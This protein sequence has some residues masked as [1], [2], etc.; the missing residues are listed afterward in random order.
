MVAVATTD[1]LDR[2]FKIS[3]ALKGSTACWRSWAG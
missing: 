3:V 2:T 1:A